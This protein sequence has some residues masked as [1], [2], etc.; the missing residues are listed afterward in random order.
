MPENSASL[1][2]SVRIKYTGQK[3]KQ[4][5]R[6]IVNRSGEAGKAGEAGE[7]G[8]ANVVQPVKSDMSEMAPS[9]INLKE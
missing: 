5:L 9:V 7:A 1:L 4:P 2:P 3:P 8:A 6:A